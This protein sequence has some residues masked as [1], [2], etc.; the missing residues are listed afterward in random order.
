MKIIIGIIFYFGPFPFCLNFPLLQHLVSTSDGFVRFIRLYFSVLTSLSFVLQNS[1]RLLTGSNEKKLKM[2]D[3]VNVDAEPVEISAHTSNIRCAMWC[4][5]D[6]HLISASDDK[7]IWYEYNS[8]ALMLNTEAK[9]PELRQK[10]QH[11]TNAHLLPNCVFIR[12]L[13][14]LLVQFGV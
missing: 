14:V 8:S 6:K 5:N 1:D 12:D 7:T 13:L 11:F 10:C 9:Y 2:F 4:S 3:L